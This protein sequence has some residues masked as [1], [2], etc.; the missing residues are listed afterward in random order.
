MV[1]AILVFW[2]RVALYP[3]ASL[4]A[5]SANQVSVLNLTVG[6]RT[7]IFVWVVHAAWSGQL[8]QR[9]YIKL[10]GQ[11]TGDGVEPR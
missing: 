8:D 5:E 9:R 1:V 4:W 6:M 7:F 10:F 2:S 3:L 11:C